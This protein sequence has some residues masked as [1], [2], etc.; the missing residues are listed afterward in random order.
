[1]RTRFALLLAPLTACAGSSY[2]YDGEP[3]AEYFPLDGQRW[4]EY[5]QCAQYDSGTPVDSSVYSFYD[6]T[7]CN[8]PEDGVLRTEKFP[9]TQ[10][11]NGIVTVQLDTYRISGDG[12]S[13]P[14]YSV[15][16][17]SDNSKG[18]RVYSWTDLT[19]GAVTAYDPPIQFAAH[20]M[21]VGDSTQTTTGGATFTTL[22]EGVRADCPNNWSGVWDECMH[23]QVSSDGPDA[24]FLGDYYIGAS[25]G[26]AAFLPAGESDV[27]VLDD[28]DWQPIEN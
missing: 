9:E 20:Q 12:S 23:L 21:N 13:T 4:W 22:F 26:L 24:P 5:R 6:P 10:S 7:G 25:Y 11:N 14:V 18:I 8:A 1:M 3:I 15:K 16:W 2:T 27:W 17:S 19:T 28:A